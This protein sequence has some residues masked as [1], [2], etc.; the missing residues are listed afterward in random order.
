M[1]ETRLILDTKNTSATLGGGR[2]KSITLKVVGR[3]WLF[4]THFVIFN[5]GSLAFY[6]LSLYSSAKS[7]GLSQVVSFVSSL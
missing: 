7:A 6:N 4:S 1:L 2:S 5:R 3:L